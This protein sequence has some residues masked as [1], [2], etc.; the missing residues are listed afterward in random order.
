MIALAF[1]AGLCVGGWTAAGQ[2]RPQRVQWEYNSLF[3]PASAP[4]A[5]PQEM[6]QLGDKGWELVSVVY[7]ERQ[8][9]YH[10]K[11]PK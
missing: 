8:R 10:F 2:Q 3:I 7:L 5:F 9:H 1:I 11:R 6:L 4:W